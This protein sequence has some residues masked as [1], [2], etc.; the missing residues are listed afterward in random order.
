MKNQITL[1]LVDDDQFD[2]KFCIREL[3]KQ[4][5]INF[6]TLEAENAAQ[7]LSI[8]Q[9]NSVDCILL[10]YQLPDT[11][12]I[13]F[14]KQLF[15]HDEQNCPVIMLTGQGSEKVAVAAMKAGA[16][17]Y[18]IKGQYDCDNLVKAIRYAIENFSLKNTIA[19]QQ[20]QLK[21]MAYHD[22]LTSLY[23]R[24]AFE[25][26]AGRVLAD[27]KRHQRLCALLYLDIDNFKT[28]ND[29]HGHNIGD[30]LLNEVSKRIIKELRQEDIVARFGGDEIVILLVSLQ[31]VSDITA[32]A[33]KITDSLRMPY[34]FGDLE[35]NTSVSMG[36]ASSESTS[37]NL[38]QLLIQADAALYEV[39][40]SGKDNFKLF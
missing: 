26:T 38:Q 31:E 37:S 1:L 32:I 33:K 11:D 6:V 19:Q 3:A 20:Q 34:H 21:K 16:T 15:E 4:Q 25:E 2:R 14:I 24:H 17:D 8:Y 23:N 18:V 12:G 40:K 30:Q 13:G 27:S 36:I 7:A 10:D 29:S 35:V 5:A 39:K 9:N 22:A 28:I